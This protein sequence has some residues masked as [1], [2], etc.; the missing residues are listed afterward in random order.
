MDLIEGWFLKG[1]AQLFIWIDYIQKREN[2]SGDLF[3]IGVH[4]GKSAILLGLMVDKTKEKLG[5]CDL[6]NIQDKNISRSGGGNKDLFLY[7]FTSFFDDI[8]FLTIYEKP[9]NMLTSDDCSKCRVFHIDGGHTTEETFLDLCL[10]SDSLVDK[11]IVIVDDI[12]NSMWPGVT[13]GFYK[14]MQERNNKLVPLI[15]AFNKL[16]LCKPNVY[17]WYK[18]KLCTAEWEKYIKKTNLIIDKKD[19]F[20][21]TVQVIGI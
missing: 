19:W 17:K 5:I 18:E 12:F 13:D 16:V 1:A 21:V 11:G 10:A 8:S 3:E 15:V 20:G 14:F 6:F 2:I 7:N 9:S 4:M